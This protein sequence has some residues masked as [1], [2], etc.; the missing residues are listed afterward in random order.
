MH[1]NYVSRKTSLL[2]E[3]DKSIK[4]VR[5]T[6][7][8]RFGQEQA[9]SLIVDSSQEYERLVPEIP[10]IGERN[11]MLFF[12]LPTSRYLAVYRTL[13]RHGRPLEEAGQ[14]VYEMGEAAIRAVPGVARQAIGYLWFS[15]LFQ[16]RL[17]R[18]A[19]ESLARQYPGGYVFHFVEGDGQ[20]FDYGVDYIECASC[21]FLKAQGA[22]ELTPYAC[23]VDKVASEML[24]W[25]LSRTMTLA[26]GHDR[27][28]FRFKKGGKTCVPLP[29]ALA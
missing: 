12:L 14:V 26:E 19:A 27:C 4:R 7:V 21:K 17:K 28:D 24:G 8:A 20:D 10:Y 13:Q 1:E 23:A 25:G 29:P 22:P 9:D 15:S 2:R 16:R 5:P 11:V 18:R 6:L 3:F